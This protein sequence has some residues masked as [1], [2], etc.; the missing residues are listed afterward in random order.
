MKDYYKILGV[1]DT[2]E[3]EVIAAAYRA[4][5][6][7]YHPDTN[8]GPSSAE[9]A[10]EINEAYEVLCD[11]GR[12]RNYDQQRQTGEGGQ[13]QEQ[14]RVRQERERERKEQ[15]ERQKRE[16]DAQAREQQER[17][18]Q[19]RIK[20][21]R[22]Q[23]EREAHAKKMASSGGKSDNKAA[24]FIPAKSFYR[25][26]LLLL[27]FP[28]VAG[29]VII[30]LTSTDQ[31]SSVQFATKINDESYD[32][33]AAYAFETNDFSVLRDLANKGHSA[34]QFYLG[35][36]YDKGDGVTEDDVVA[37]N[38]YQR[39]ADQGNVKAQYNLGVMH[40]TGQ[41]VPQYYAAAVEWFRKAGEQGD[42]RAQYR[43]GLAYSTGTGVDRDYVQAHKWLNLAAAGAKDVEIRTK[44]IRSRDSLAAKMSAAG[45]A[46]AQ[47]LAGAWQSRKVTV[48]K[49]KS[50]RSG[51]VLNPA[52]A[53]PRNRQIGQSV[54]K[55]KTA[56][57]APELKVAPSATMVPR[58]GSS[59]GVNNPA[60]PA[61]RANVFSDDDYPS[62][63]RAASEQGLVIA[64][65]VVGVDGR[66]SQCEIVQSSG[67]KRLDDAT[68]SIIQR[69]FRFL[70]VSRFKSGRLSH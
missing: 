34:A 58:P 67:F 55:L 54:P 18:R 26:Q 50:L 9:K 60:T 11:A 15:T 43:L 40:A 17:E 56:P 19:E 3:V 53:A 37:V 32:R 4:L 70:M 46:E 12:R 30:G 49:P 38:W 20:R 63:S 41:G 36:A 25:S 1:S 8:P 23:Q 10:K 22:E 24:P 48:A 47:R 57:R 42:V 45:I 61:G 7:K 39:A 68:C 35:L 6:H 31:A 28:V 27:G 52:L 69:R 21:E 44:A 16:Q 64:S 33:R 59:S 14:E 62:A 5:M 66:V 51:A 65:Y 13:S 2:A 29:L